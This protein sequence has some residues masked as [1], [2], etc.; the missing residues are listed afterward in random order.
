[1]WVLKLNLLLAQRV[2]ALTGG[3]DYSHSVQALAVGAFSIAAPT[4]HS[5]NEED[6][7]QET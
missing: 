3:N 5:S 4:P 6:V 2:D 7:G 1:M